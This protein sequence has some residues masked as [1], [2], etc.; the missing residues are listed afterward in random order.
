MVFLVMNTWCLKQVV[1]TKNWIKTLIWKVCILLVYV[2][3]VLISLDTVE[4]S[5]FSV[6]NTLFDSN[7]NIIFHE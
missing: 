4:Q 2:N 3:I 1:D 7:S 5:G 6:Y